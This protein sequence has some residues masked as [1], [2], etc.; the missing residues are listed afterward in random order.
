MLDLRN[1]D[2]YQ[3]GTKVK[4]IRKYVAEDPIR[5]RSLHSSGSFIIQPAALYGEPPIMEEVNPD[6]T[7]VRGSVF[8]A[9][10]PYLT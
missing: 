8:R 1:K 5:H 2:V 7:K 4:P 9:I 3:G 6:G 10:I